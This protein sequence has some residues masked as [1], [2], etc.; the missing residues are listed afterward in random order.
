V[1]GIADLLIAV[2]DQ[3]DLGLPAGQVVENVSLGDDKCLRPQGALQQIRYQAA[4]YC[5]RL[6]EAVDRAKLVRLEDRFQCPIGLIGECLPR[7]EPVLEG[8]PLRVGK[9][10]VSVGNAF[11]PKLKI[12]QQLQTPGGE[13]FRLAHRLASQSDPRI[14]R[15]IGR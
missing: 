7:S 12:V 1:D 6:Y 3:I 2:D 8:I 11:A 9:W 4:V 15:M 13:W 14:K 5:T 10:D